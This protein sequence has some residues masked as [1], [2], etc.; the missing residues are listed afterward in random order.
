MRLK[1]KVAL[2]TG[3]GSGIGQAT[4]EKFA[5]E[6]ARLALCDL[7]FEK[8][9]RVAEEIAAAGTDTMALRADV[10]RLA[11]MNIA[12]RHVLEA[13]GRVDVLVNNAGITRD[14]TLKNMTEERFDEVIAVNL[15][16]VYNSAQAVLPAMLAQG[17]GVIL[18]ASSVVGLYDN[19][20]Q[21]SYA[22]TQF[23]VIG[24]TKTWARELAR[25]GI[26]ANAVCPGFI[27]ADMVR[28]MPDKVLEEIT[29]RVPQGR[30]G[31]PEEVA[32]VYA[33]LASDEATYVNGAVIEVSGGVTL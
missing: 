20:G 18:N 14:A 9:A 33:F 13:Y 10:S 23:G 19:F 27:G 25:K 2:I 8:V 26:R 6:G 32:N 11:D 16:G 3:A 30:L 22:A 15:K 5:R 17:G 31:T 1:D 7:N 4:A 21:T 28:A 12:V 24:M 29:S